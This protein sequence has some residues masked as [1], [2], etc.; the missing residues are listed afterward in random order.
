MRVRRCAKDRG[1]PRHRDARPGDRVRLLDRPSRP[2]PTG[3][4]TAPPAR[5][6]SHG[7]ERRRVRRAD[8]PDRRHRH[9]GR[10]ATP[11][12]RARPAATGTPAHGHDRPTGPTG[13]SG[14]PAPPAPRP[15]VASRA[16]A[17]VGSGTC[18]ASWP[19]RWRRSAAT[20]G[21][22]AVDLANGQVLFDDAA[23]TPR[24]PASVEK[25]YTLTTAL[26]RFGL[27]GTLET[28]VYA[29][30]HARARTAS[31]DGNLY[32]RGGGDPTFGDEHFINEWYGGVGTSVGALALKLIAAMH[33]HKI[34]GS[35]IG[36]ESEFDSLRGG[37]STDY[38][39]DPNLVGELSALAF[40][41]G[42][43]DGARARPPPT[44]RSASP[45][46]CA[47][48]GVVVT[49]RSQA[50]VMDRAHARAW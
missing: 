25:L 19:R 40:D 46:R 32:L 27:D 5:R 21:A 14:A 34:E 39:V 9:T 4:A 22:Y 29:D 10:P 30:G 17:A 38:A 28:S 45:A 49:G 26:A 3:G 16:A 42:E 11:A 1:A 15:D 41:R 44:R 2:S 18:S 13:T 37:P 47:R 8:R 43:T 24:N 23:S 36:D 6:G 31:S 7:R 20:P 12:P 50:G 33:V 48:H 35:M